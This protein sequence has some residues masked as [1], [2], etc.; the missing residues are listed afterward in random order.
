MATVLADDGVRISYRV[1]GEGPT[2]V[3]FMHGWAGSVVMASMK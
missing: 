1:E 2:T 3:L